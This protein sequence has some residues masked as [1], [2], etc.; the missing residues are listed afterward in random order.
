[1]EIKRI[2]LREK[3]NLSMEVADRVFAVRDYKYDGDSHYY[4]VT[5]VVDGTEYIISG[6]DLYGQKIHAELPSGSFADRKIGENLTLTEAWDM[7]ATASR[8]YRFI[9]LFDFD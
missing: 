2:S 6:F 5:K 4:Y 7:Y 9:S 3:R 1:M 8:D